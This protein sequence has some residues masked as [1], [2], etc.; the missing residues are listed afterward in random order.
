MR[1]LYA[2]LLLLAAARPADLIVTNGRVYTLAWPDPAKD[3]TPSASAPYDAKGGWHPDAEA[4][5]IREGRVVWTGTSAGVARYRGPATR[6]IDAHGATVLPGLIDSHVHIANLGEALSRVN[7]VGVRD[8]AEAVERVA[9]R[10]ATTKAGEWIVGYGWD[11]GAWANHYP[12]MRLLSERVPDHP[13]LLRGLH[14]FAAWGNRLAFER[15]GI[16]ADTPAPTGGEI[17]KDAAGQPTG[18]VLNSAVALIERA[19]P[20]PPPEE[21]DA[22][23]LAGLDAIVRAGF[24][25][26]HE[27]GADT[28][29]VAAFERLAAGRKLPVTVY[30]MLAGRDEALLRRWL[31]RGP[32]KNCGDASLCIR[33]VKFFY[34]GALGSR[35]ARLT[36]EYSDKPGWLGLGGKDYGFHS[37]LADQAL[38]AGFQVVVHAIGDA[39]NHDVL[40]LFDK[41]YAKALRPR[42]EHAQVVAPADFPRFSREGVIASMQPSHAVEDMPWAEARVGAERI[43]GAYAWRTLR[44]EGARLALNSDLPGTDYDVF[45]GL[46]SAVT[47]RDRNHKP[48]GGWRSEQR[49]TPEEAV[50]G[51]TTW[52]AYA[53]FE[54]NEMGSIRPGRL[55]NLTILDV[56]P[57]DAGTRDPER[58]LDGKVLMTIVQGKVLY[59]RGR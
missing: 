16:K 46:H 26:V 22:R 45:Y 13:V 27:A 44:R 47:R 48:E 29:E 15:A 1:T 18:I 37:Q 19:I 4:V 33:S 59:E 50:R 20:A 17:R 25:A 34:D 38:R 43:R 23:L 2:L 51:F 28:A 21:S 30:L 49:L 39:A 54:E 12:D 8:E 10:A 31:Q 35:G 36:S 32:Q 11:E 5:A 9:Q 6:V 53:G 24:T 14:S 41:P 42:I 40:D 52:A 58:L 55:G 56:D 57:F 3:G 7:L